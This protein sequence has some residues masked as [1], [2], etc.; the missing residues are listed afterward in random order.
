ML[1]GC[2]LLIVGSPGV[3]ELA[4]LLAGVWGVTPD[5]IDLADA[6]DEGAERNWTATVLCEY[7][8]V[9]GDVRLLLQVYVQEWMASPPDEAEAAG[10]LAR[11]AGRTVLYPVGEYDYAAATPAG[12]VIRVRVVE[13]DDEHEPWRVTM[14]EAPVPGLGGAV[15]EPLPEKLRAVPLATP[16]TDAF[17]A[18]ADPDGTLPGDAP[19][20]R[21]RAALLH[22]ERLVRRMAEGWPPDGTYRRDL[23][24]DDLEARDDLSELGLPAPVRLDLD[25]RLAV[26]DAE[27]TGLTVPGAPVSGA[28]DHAAWWWQRRPRETPRVE[29][30]GTLR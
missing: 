17:R 5:D 13:P 29:G 19:E 8:Q 21:A 2:L 4:R 20:N 27:F 30:G 11:L 14:A 9:V 12:D 23:Y 10:R 16:A 18:C 24:A 7:R 6:A 1:M 3:G 26:L 28:T 22:W 25:A 15:V